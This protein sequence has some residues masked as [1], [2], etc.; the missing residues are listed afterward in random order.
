MGLLQNPVSANLRFDG[1]SSSKNLPK[2]RL[3]SYFKEAVPKPEILKQFHIIVGYKNFRGDC[4]V[5]C[6]RLLA[7]RDSIEAPV[8]KKIRNS[9]F[10]EL[11]TGVKGEKRAID[12]FSPEPVEKP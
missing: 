6:L 12:R 5:Y 8:K 1:T 7:I 2:A 9:Q 11:G 10:R 4:Q 3:F